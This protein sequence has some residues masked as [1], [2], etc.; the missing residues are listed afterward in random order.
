MLV[1]DII[2]NVFKKNLDNCSS[3]NKTNEI[4]DDVKVKNNY[5]VSKI[6]IVVKIVMIIVVVI[7]MILVRLILVVWWWLWGGMGDIVITR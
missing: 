7:I 2:I 3:I 5:K 4:G 6:K 1:A